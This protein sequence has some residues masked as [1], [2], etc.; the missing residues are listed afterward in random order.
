MDTICLVFLL[1]IC[2][3][4][5]RQTR[6]FSL[7]SEPLRSIW[8]RCWSSWRITRYTHVPCRLHTVIKDVWVKLEETIYVLFFPY[9]IVKQ[10]LN[11]IMIL[12][13]S[14]EARISGWYVYVVN[15]LRYIWLLD[16][17]TSVI[18]EWKPR[19]TFFLV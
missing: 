8:S 6:R 9:C 7:T 19:T 17:L 1:C 15:F 4:G 18:N 12:C 2:P 3:T 13:H 5:S 16:K 11:T 14:A 10:S